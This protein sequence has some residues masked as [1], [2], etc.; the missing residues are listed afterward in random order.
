MKTRE[1]LIS[2]GYTIETGH[3]NPR[4]IGFEKNNVCY[5]LHH[6]FS[7]EDLDIEEYISIGI[8]N[9][10]TVKFGTYEFPMLP[11]LSNGLVLLDLMRNHLQTGL[12]LRQVIDWMMYVYRE[13]SD[14]FWTTEFALVVRSLGLEKFAI[15]ITRMCQL[16]LGLPE[17]ITWCK[18]ADV[19]IC[20]NLLNVLFCSGN[21]GRKSGAGHS[22][23]TVRMLIRKHGFFTWL[24]IAG[25]HNWKAYK[26]YHWLK[27]LCWI[28][29]M[30]RYV[31]R[32]IMLRRTY[33]QLSNDN[34]RS[35]SR[36]DLM[37][38][39]GLVFEKSN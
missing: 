23:E 8:N 34:Y 32:G 7:H 12:V 27:P 30:A 18:D 3:E 25:E 20:R 10:T 31:R 4:H 28:Y 21:F 29:Q 35:K 24:Q 11:K 1:I 13:L 9:R 26:K 16:Y 33:S 14:E 19:E 37:K 15:V 2:N 5:E 17:T 22:V 38:K 39:M 6:H 36:Y